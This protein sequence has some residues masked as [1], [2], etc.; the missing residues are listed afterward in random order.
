MLILITGIVLF[1][2]IHILS[3][4]RLKQRLLTSV[5][6][7]TYKGVYALI[8][9]IG[10]VL[11]IF[12]HAKAPYQHVWLAFPQWRM[13]TLP[14]MWLAFVLLPAAHMPGNIKRITRHP[15]LW[16]VWLWSSAH[17][18]V[19]GDLA[20]ILTFG[21]FWCYSLYAMVSQNLRGAQKQTD[22][23][24]VKKDLIVFAAGTLVFILVIFLHGL[25]FGVPL[26]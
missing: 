22:K 17:L 21:S 24:P 6:E 25:L 7:Q 4:L 5:G 11:I 1:F 20:S 15:M 2:A 26:R 14:V 18:M 9:L 3:S 19:N 8:S 10:L 12:G 13:M 23:L 16:G